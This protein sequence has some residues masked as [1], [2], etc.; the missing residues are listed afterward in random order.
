MSSHMKHPHLL[1]PVKGPA[2]SVPPLLLRPG[3][4]SCTSPFVSSYR[5]LLFH[6]DPAF[7][8]ERCPEC[9]SPDE[10]RKGWNQRLR[11]LLLTFKA[12]L[13]GTY[14]GSVAFC[15]LFCHRL[16][17]KGCILCPAE[18]FKT[19][20]SVLIPEVIGQVGL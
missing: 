8:Q 16:K 13:W 4:V 6:C 18:E 10:R 12:S 3:S 7:I 2:R 5:E 1:I 20:E 15:F 19:P 11:V 9:S 14:A 17:R